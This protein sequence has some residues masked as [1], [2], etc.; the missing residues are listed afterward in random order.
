MYFVG[1]ACNIAT[2]GPDQHM[3][4]SCES[5]AC[6]VVPGVLWMKMLVPYRA[7]ELRKLAAGLYTTACRHRQGCFGSGVTTGM[8][9]LPGDLVGHPI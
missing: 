1:R 6:L 7:K 4:W 2:S 8:L 5:H 3:A 9:Q